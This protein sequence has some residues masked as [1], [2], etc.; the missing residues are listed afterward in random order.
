M[1]SVVS[2]YHY[3]HL[4]FFFFLKPAQT[5]LKV[6]S[7]NCSFVTAKFQGEYIYNN[8]YFV[9]AHGKIVIV[10]NLYFSMITHLDTFNKLYFKKNVKYIMP[11]NPFLSIFYAL[12]NF[13]LDTIKCSKHFSK[14]QY[15]L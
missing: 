3:C 8:L 15:D 13:L 7:L 12:F 5:Y 9:Y 14:L 2:V 6:N 11:F 4:L 1:K 10:N